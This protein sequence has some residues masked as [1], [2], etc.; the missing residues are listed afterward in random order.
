MSKSHRNKWKS[1]DSNSSLSSGGSISQR[2]VHTSMLLS[3]YMLSGV[4]GSCEP[5]ILIH[6]RQMSAITDKV[7]G[8]EQR[9]R[10]V[11]PKH[12]V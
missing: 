8:L 6:C 9:L 11:V 12:H 1:S 10:K 7:V 2:L 5:K 4:P 3:L